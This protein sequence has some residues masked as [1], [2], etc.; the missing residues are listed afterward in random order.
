MN[1]PIKR[2]KSDDTERNKAAIS[3]NVE[4]DLYARHKHIE[5]SIQ[6]NSFQ[7]KSNCNVQN[8]NVIKS[9]GWT[10]SDEQMKDSNN[11]LKDNNNKVDGDGDKM[12]TDLFTSE[13]LQPSYADLNKIFDNS[14]DNSNDEHVSF[15]SFHLLIS[16][17]DFC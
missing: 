5:S 4:Y 8:S 1:H 3:R 10:N 6:M 7:N 11:V 2:F 17:I 16:D 13:G 12:S 15:C 9:E 14:D